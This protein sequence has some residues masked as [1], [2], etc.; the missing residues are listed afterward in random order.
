M[1][2]SSKAAGQAGQMGLR[3][4]GPGGRREQSSAGAQFPGDLRH[5]GGDGGEKAPAPGPPPQIDDDDGI[6]TVECAG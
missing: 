6:E 5:V 4:G 3:H 1:T 2:A